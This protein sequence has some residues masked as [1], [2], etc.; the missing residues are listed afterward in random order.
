VNRRFQPVVAVLLSAVL[1]VLPS[2]GARAQRDDTSIIRDAETEAAITAM[3]APIF[4]AAG[5]NVPDIHIALVQDPRINAFVAGGQNIFVNTGLILET[6]NIGELLGVIAHETGHISGGHLLRAG[7][8]MENASYEA[9]LAMILGAAAAA[10]TRDAGAIAGAIG[11]GQEIGMRSLMAFSRGQESAADQAAIK[12]LNISK[13]SANGMLTF[14][15]KLQTQEGMPVNR[16][17][18]YVRT[19]PLTGD[20]VEAVRFAVSQS[21]Y[22]RVQPPAADE[23][24]Y[25]RIKAKL[26]GYMQPS[27]ALRRYS[28]AEPS[29]FGRYARA[30]ALFRTGQLPQ[31]LTT[32]D[33]LIADQP[34]NPYLYEM[35]GQMLFENSRIAEAV[36]V[37]RKA[38]ELAP[39]EPLIR[40]AS[41][42][43]LLE[44]NKPESLDPAIADLKAAASREDRMPLVHRLLATAYGRKGEDTAAQLELAEEALL[45]GEVTTARRL[46]ERVMR[47]LPPGSRPWLRAQDIL[48]ASSPLNP[49]DLDK[50][51]KAE[52]EDRRRRGL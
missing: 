36:P 12:F 8:A 24:R 37:L 42:Q 35:K 39:N 3:A 17:V 22:S 15:Q 25:Q 26:L 43:A 46:S 16:Q 31:A 21:P 2:S 44:T 52:R 27:V 30:I 48:S 34:Q 5:L 41:G 6:R 32:M 47:V 19:H 51:E 23:E 50:M 20:R 29:F 9:I 11:G 49:K 1:S 13:Q 4:K 45:Q 28:R 14:F 10:A 7:G 38:V 33:G 40:L 18:E